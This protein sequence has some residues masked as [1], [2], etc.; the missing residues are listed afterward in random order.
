VKN[1]EH[2]KKKEGWEELLN[3][4]THTTKTLTNIHGMVAE[5][6]YYFQDYANNTTDYFMDNNYDDKILFVFEK[7]HNIVPRKF[8]GN[9]EKYYRIL[10]ND[11]EYRKQ[12]DDDDIEVDPLEESLDEKSK[13]AFILNKVIFWLDSPEWIKSDLQNDVLNNKE[14]SENSINIS[15]LSKLLLFRQLLSK[16]SFK[17]LYIIRQLPYFIYVIR[18]CTYISQQIK[19]I[20]LYY[21]FYNLKILLLRPFKDKVLLVYWH[22][23]KYIYINYINYQLILASKSIFNRKFIILLSY[24]HRN[25]KVKQSETLLNN[26]KKLTVFQ[27]FNWALIYENLRTVFFYRQFNQVRSVSVIYT[28][29]DKYR[30]WARFKKASTIFKIWTVADN[31][32]HKVNEQSESVYYKTLMPWQEEV[33]YKK[34]QYLYFIVAIFL[35]IGLYK[36][37]FPYNWYQ[38]YVALSA[39]PFLIFYDYKDLLTL[40]WSKFKYP[41]F[42]HY[43]HAWN[44]QFRQYTDIV[45]H[46]NVKPQPT[47]MQSLSAKEKAWMHYRNFKYKLVHILTKTYN[48]FHYL[49]NKRY[50]DIKPKKV[51]KRSS[52]YKWDKKKPRSLLSMYDDPRENDLLNPLSFEPINFQYNLRLWKE[53]PKKVAYPTRKYAEATDKVKMISII[54]KFILKKQNDVYENKL[55]HIKKNYI[56]TDK[57][58][59]VNKSIFNYIKTDY[60]KKMIAIYKTS[61]QQLKNTTIE[62]V[63]AQIQKLNKKNKINQPLLNL[64]EKSFINQ[65]LLQGLLKTDVDMFLKGLRLSNQKPVKAIKKG[66][67]VKRY[68][69]AKQQV[70]LPPAISFTNNKVTYDFVFTRVLLKL[71]EYLPSQLDPLQKTIFICVHK[72]MDLFYLASYF[73]E[74][75][76]E[77]ISAQG[78]SLITTIYKGLYF[79]DSITLH[80]FHDLIEIITSNQFTTYLHKFKNKQTDKKYQPLIYVPNLS[81][82]FDA[83]AFKRVL[84]NENQY[85]YAYKPETVK[86]MAWALQGEQFLYAIF[87]WYLQDAKLKSDF[88]KQLQAI[89][90]MP[91]DTEDLAKQKQIKYNELLNS[92]RK[93]SQSPHL[94]L[95]DKA[96]RALIGKF[97]R[98]I[99]RSL[100]YLT[101]NHVR[102]IWL[103]KFSEANYYK[104][105]KQYQKT[106]PSWPVQPAYWNKVE[107]FSE[108]WKVWP[109]EIADVKYKSKRSSNLPHDKYYDLYISRHNYNNTL[110]WWQSK[111]SI[112]QFIKKFI[113]VRYQAD[114]QHKQVQPTLFNWW[115]FNKYMFI[116]PQLDMIRWAQEGFSDSKRADFTLQYLME[117][118]KLSLRKHSS[119][120]LDEKKA[121]AWYRELY[122]WILTHPRFSKLELDPSYQYDFSW[123]N[124]KRHLKI[125]N[126]EQ[127]WHLTDYFAKFQWDRNSQYDKVIDWIENAAG[128]DPAQDWNEIEQNLIKLYWDH[129]TRHVEQYVTYNLKQFLKFQNLSN[130][131]VY[132]VDKYRPFKQWNGEIDTQPTFTTEHL[133]YD[134]MLNLNLQDTYMWN[135]DNW[136][137][138]SNKKKQQKALIDFRAKWVPK[139]GKKHQILQSYAKPHIVDR[140]VWFEDY[141]EKDFMEL[142]KFYLTTKMFIDRYQDDINYWYYTGKF[143]RNMYEPSYLDD[144]N[145]AVSQF[146]TTEYYKQPRIIKHK[147]DTKL[148][149]IEHYYKILYTVWNALLRAPRYLYN[150]FFMG[151]W[152]MKYM[153]VWLSYTNHSIQKYYHFKTYEYFNVWHNNIDFYNYKYN[154]YKAYEQHTKRIDKLINTLWPQFEFW[155]Y[156]TLHDQLYRR[157]AFKK[158]KIKYMIEREPWTT[159]IYKLKRLLKQQEEDWYDVAELMHQYTSFHEWDREDDMDPTRPYTDKERLVEY[160]L[161]ISMAS[162]KT[163]RQLY[164]QLMKNRKDREELLTPTILQHVFKKFVVALPRAVYIR[165]R[166]KSIM[167]ETFS[168]F[169]E[170]RRGDIKRVVEQMP[171]IIRKAKRIMRNRNKQDKSK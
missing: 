71:S 168:Y 118:H 107:R 87:K 142:R 165:K 143:G 126:T 10:Y 130:R 35:Y 167:S 11:M 34:Y 155:N 9:L 44:E 100:P 83:K 133:S 81:T 72:I 28:I 137:R 149:R 93:L 27:R 170:R 41:S 89:S 85:E 123:N 129:I 79:F 76:G 91:E 7:K 38:L 147:E 37:V 92:K 169:K 86:H 54:R 88:N 65:Y 21:Q 59:K 117:A 95:T 75:S 154:P 121:M 114:L 131:L 135:A 30:S 25:I 29:V 113:S 145:I 8:K 18:G 156:W 161:R 3:Y 49:L 80:T 151:T 108:L 122:W 82:Q 128:F 26:V 24:Y 69:R 12:D 119:S 58:K 64:S 56:R 31:K 157:I 106:I 171:Q 55:E 148:Y 47:Y 99:D 57:E 127:F 73:I 2:L 50:I 160:Y 77:F 67:Y 163:N 68:M 153:K 138:E 146:M 40:C 52:W 17:I 63:E 53:K 43:F 120:T 84:I 140:K 109:S 136:Q 159:K 22:Y 15:K 103:P 139:A 36:F 101:L 111:L 125:K 33:F 1:I 19:V 110:S 144:S 4:L 98:N 105:V 45:F 42:I 162:H 39:K 97:I 62:D 115:K 166:K 134:E 158:P 23:I 78:Q 116:K 66:P 48:E 152:Y 60:I 94:K 5:T 61:I 13:Q 90:K 51:K 102:E 150:L 132:L 20:I 141:N 164:I 74:K 104:D 124:K 14:L 46:L 16:V 96:R 6:A 112:R 70:K 32:Q